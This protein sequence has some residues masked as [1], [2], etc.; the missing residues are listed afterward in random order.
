MLEQKT[1]AFRLPSGF[2]AVSVTPAET[3]TFAATDAQEK[4]IYLFSATGV[5]LESFETIRPYEKLQRSVTGPTAGTYLA[6]G[7]CNCGRRVFLLN[8]RFE[9]VGS[10]DL[11][12]SSDSGCADIGELVDA[13]PTSEGDAARIH[14]AFRQSVRIFDYNGQQLGIAIPPEDG[15]TN[16]H[17]AI[18][19]PVRALH[20]RRN[21]TEFVNIAEM[22]A[23]YLGVVPNSMVLRGFLPS[24]FHD[25]YG[26]FG[27]RYL[28]NYLI[29]IYLNSSFVLPVTGEMEH[30]LQNIRS[31]P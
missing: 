3:D 18:S 21:Q 1:I 20:F 10:I 28:Y 9:E 2:P 6:T 24:G 17:Y 4:A 29:P 25:L 8:C 13:S 11:H 5:F 12:P 31:C 30:I 22:G 16:L 15:R 26:L 27:Y 7:Q 19:G 14:A 23:V